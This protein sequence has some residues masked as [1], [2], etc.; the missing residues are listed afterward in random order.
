MEMMIASIIARNSS[1]DPDDIL[2]AK[3]VLN[4]LGL[5]VPAR[6]VGMTRF[7]DPALFDALKAFQK[8]AGLPETGEVA[9]DDDTWQALSDA[10]RQPPGDDEAYIWTTMEDD[11]VRPSHIKRQGRRF[12]W[13]DHPWPG[14]ESDCRCWAVMVPEEERPAGTSANPPQH[15]LSEPWEKLVVD[16]LRKF[17]GDV[18]HPY[19]D[20]RGF[21][22]VGVGTNVSREAT[23]LA[24]PWRIGDENGRMATAAEIQEGYNKL[25]RYIAA[26]M[27][28]AAAQGRQTLNLPDEHYQGITN[29][30]LPKMERQQMAERDLDAFQRELN[31]KFSGFNTIPAPAKVALMDMIYNI[32]GT[33]FT[34]AKWPSLFAA[35]SARD[36]EKAAAESRRVDVNAR[37]NS[38]TAALFKRAAEISRSGGV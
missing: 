24:L 31:A 21:L 33:K 22:T 11:R 2:T 38:S 20:S 19:G 17:E 15:P 7:A 30:R 35:V 37:R 13:K 4:R 26:R 25:T 1:P 34:A 29:L 32:G 23:F 12:L 3:R 27:E 36:W 8:R 28:E 5:Y 6:E 9:P 10:Y 18:A 14:E 16:G